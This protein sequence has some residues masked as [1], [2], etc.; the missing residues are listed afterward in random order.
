MFHE[1]F[2]QIKDKI[3]LK[4]K[5][6]DDL[7]FYEIGPCS[8]KM[9]GMSIGI[10]RRNGSLSMLDINRKTKGITPGKVLDNKCENTPNI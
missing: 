10:Q 7:N 8:C 6:S 2:Y 4:F 1:F 3:N 9:S 5:T